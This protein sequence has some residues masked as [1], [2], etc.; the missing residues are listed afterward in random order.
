MHPYVW[1]SVQRFR[2]NTAAG[3]W[4]RRQNVNKSKWNWDRHNK[5]TMEREIN[6][7]ILCIWGQK[8]HLGIR[9]PQ[10]GTVAWKNHADHN[11]THIYL[12]KQVIRFIIRGGE[13]DHHLLCNAKPRIN[14]IFIYL[15][16][17]FHQVSEMFFLFIFQV[18][19]KYCSAV[20]GY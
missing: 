10:T 18:L 2:G 17:L 3:K 7:V 12:E 1:S 6:E 8:G 13:A 20:N 15:E 16:F 11:R 4:M 14:I 5:Q 19:I 9:A